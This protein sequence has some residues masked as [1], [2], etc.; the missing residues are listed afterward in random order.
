MSIASELGN[1]QLYL[2]NAYTQAGGK[3]AV[4]PTNKNMMNLASCIGSIIIGGNNVKAAKGT[5][6]ITGTPTNHTISNLGFAPSIV[7]VY[8]VN[9]Q[10]TGGLT[11]VWI[12]TSNLDYVIY[13]TSSGS[14]SI[15]SGDYTT[16]EADGFTIERR[17]STYPIRAGEYQYVAIE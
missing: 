17:S 6:T 14:P 7:L 13:E 12:K 15:V 5:F 3:G 16:L 10:A 1:L 11:T 4:I 8:L 9:K 2:D